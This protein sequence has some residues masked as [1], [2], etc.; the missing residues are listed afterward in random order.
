MKC[1]CGYETNLIDNIGD[2]DFIKL[3]LTVTISKSWENDESV[4]LYACPK[5]N[6]IQM[7]RW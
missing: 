7:S 6:T 2:E 4:A 1:I 3:N 5:C